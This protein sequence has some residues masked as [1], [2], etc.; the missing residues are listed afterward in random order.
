MCK[1]NK[2]VVEFVLIKIDF[3]ACG[4]IQSSSVFFNRGFAVPQSSTKHV[5][6]FVSFKGSVRVPHFFKGNDI[7]LHYV[8]ASL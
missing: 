1:S 5:V 6:G 8:D 3:R 2:C 4:E 7:L